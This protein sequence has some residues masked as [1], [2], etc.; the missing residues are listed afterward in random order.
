MHS[1]M[2]ILGVIDDPLPFSSHGIQSPLIYDVYDILTILKVMNSGI[3]ISM[4]YSTQQYC[5][6]CHFDHIQVQP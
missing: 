6:Y 2:H 4:M 1:R 5:R 3:K